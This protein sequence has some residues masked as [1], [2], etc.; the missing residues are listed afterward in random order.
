VRQLDVVPR[1]SHRLG[2]TPS[3]PG[4]LH[5]RRWWSWVA[6][7][8]RSPASTFMR[9][10]PVDEATQQPDFFAFRSQLQMAL[11]CSDATALLACVHP[12]IRNSYGPDEGID[13]FRTRWLPFNRNSRIWEALGSALTLGG[14][15]GPDN[16]FLAPYVFSR[17]PFEVDARQHTAIIGLAA[18]ARMLP[19]VDFPVLARCGLSIVPLA[20]GSDDVSS[21]V[22][23]RTPQGQTAYVDKRWVRSPLDFRAIFEKRRGRWWLTAFFSSD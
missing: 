22:A 18:E 21:W 4:R 12:D 8:Q 9:F 16:M 14:T 3:T 7:R 15:F 17:W 23:I 20:L 13:R 5:P 19:L 6:A 10:D 1:E 11:L 2:D